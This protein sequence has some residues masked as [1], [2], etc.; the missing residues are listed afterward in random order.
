LGADTVCVL[1]PKPAA[2]RW[3]DP[4][5]QWREVAAKT[6][7][8]YTLIGQASPKGGWVLHLLSEPQP[9]CA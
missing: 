8:S 1:P 4:S 2:L 3:F 7:G 6:R 9:L 5:T